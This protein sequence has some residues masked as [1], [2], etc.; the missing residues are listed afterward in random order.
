MRVIVLLLAGGGGSGGGG[1]VTATMSFESC[2]RVHSVKHLG[3]RGRSGLWD[4]GGL[5]CNLREANNNR[6]RA[7]T[8]SHGECN[9][10]FKS[11]K[12]ALQG[13]DKLLKK[14]QFM[15]FP[16]QGETMEYGC[17]S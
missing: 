13:L 2:E 15:G 8:L 5:R 1:N 7:R 16:S 14:G 10:S 12:L 6:P 4:V 9:K 11:F 17:P 3:W